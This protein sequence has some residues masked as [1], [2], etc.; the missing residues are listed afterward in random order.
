M[1]AIPEPLAGT[2]DARNCARKQPY[3]TELNARINAQAVINDTRQWRNTPKRMWVYQCSHC[4]AWHMTTA[5]GLN[6]NSRAVN[7][8]EL[9][10]G[11][12]R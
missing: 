6:G 10:E 2:L 11:T 7:R 1:A 5:A 12:G 3:T 4:G 8:R 9:Y